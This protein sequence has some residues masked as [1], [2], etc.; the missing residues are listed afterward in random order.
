[1][2]IEDILIDEN[3]EDD[4]I[5]IDV[6]SPKEF[7]ADHINGSINLP[8]LYDNEYDEVGYLYKNISRFEANKKG[9]IY[10]MKNI[11]HHIETKLKN[12]SRK[13]KIIFYCSRGGNRSQSFAIVCSKI[14]WNSDIIKGGY[15][16][17]RRHVV[18]QINVLSRNLN[19]IIIAGKTGV[20]KTDILKLLAKKDI[21]ILDLEYLASHRGSL[22][23]SF[24]SIK[25]P[26]Q[27]MFESRLY[28]VINKIDEGSIIFVESESIK[29]GNVQIPKELFDSIYHSPLIKIENSI[30]ERAKYLVENYD[31]LKG[32]FITISNLLKFMSL[33]KSKSLIGLLENSLQEKDWFKLAKLL[34][35]HHCDST[36]DFAMSKRKG[37]VIADLKF[38]HPVKES[39]EIVVSKILTLQREY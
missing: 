8:V 26:S 33:R 9:S 16:S 5:I 14:G 34:L 23:G 6:R 17:Y 1:M 2:N 35:L 29:I 4:S 27:K 22:L 21:N 12:I 7:Y 18:K 25:Q 11:S 13:N 3:S 37:R 39:V 30:N 10:V 31:H 20:G 36:Y 19:F 38:D 24:I 32:D 15:K 28:D